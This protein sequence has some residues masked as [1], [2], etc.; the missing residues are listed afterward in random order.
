MYRRYSQMGDGSMPLSQVNRNRIKN[1]IIFLLLAALAAVLIISLPA[2]TSRNETRSLYIRRIQ[3]ECDDAARQTSTLSRN[4]GADSAAILAKIRCNIYAIR[5]LN[6]M[7][8]SAGDRQFIEDE[9]LLTLQNTVDRYLS[10]L[11]TGMDTGE[12]QTSLQTALAELQEIA[13]SL[14]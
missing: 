9:R 7:G 4:A 13:G 6:T 1:I 8:A 2:L 10:F 11:T 3:A 5:T 14:N 12:Y